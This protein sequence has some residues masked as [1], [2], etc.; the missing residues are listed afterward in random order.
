MLERSSPFVNRILRLLTLAA[1][2][3]PTLPAIAAAEPRLFGFDKS[4][5]EVGFDIR[6]FFTKVH[7]RFNDYAGSI[8]YDPGNLEA[9]TVSVSI[10]DSSIYTANDRRDSD[11]RSPN[12]FDVAKNPT[13][14]FKSTKVIPGK[15]ASHF[16]V[17]GD[18]NM[19][20]VTK[21]VTLDVEFLGMGP[22]AVSGRSMGTQAGFVGKTTIKRE[23]WGIT[24]NRTLDQGGMMLGE[25][26]E[27]TLNI[28]AVSQDKPAAPAAAPAADKK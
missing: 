14:T 5:S 28:A 12:F 11:L 7:G 10:A 13:I 6:H 2:L 25:D 15:D 21:P 9:S 16:Q 22:V 8:A 23:D 24:W 19:H 1:V 26:V 18:L 20:G 17:A 4:H 27:I 3:A